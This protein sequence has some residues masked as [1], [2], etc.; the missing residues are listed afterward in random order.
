MRDVNAVGAPAGGPAP[1]PGV[2]ECL[3]FAGE[4]YLNLGRRFGGFLL[5]ALPWVILD[6]LAQLLPPV[7]AK[8]GVLLV[9]TFAGGSAVAVGTHR[10]LLLGETAIQAMQLRL[11][12]LQFFLLSAFAFAIALLV[13]V[14]VM[15]F[16]AA[17]TTQDEAFL[18]PLGAI[19]E[20]LIFL[21]LVSIRLLAFPA[22]AVGERGMRFWR[23]FASPGIPARA[24]WA[25]LA[26]T[27]LAGFP[28]LAVDFALQVA[29]PDMALV[30]A[31][32]YPLLVLAMAA[33]VAGYSSALY[34]R[35]G[36]DAA[37]RAARP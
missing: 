26:G 18:V 19:L 37:V 21:A 7:P 29:A 36:R 12:V 24:Q 4:S 10:I 28:V 6:V 16:I 31:F 13:L 23:A 27:L 33:L 20:S 1:W 35:M 5:L 14:A 25:T 9:I 34:R 15:P 17:L 8:T 22:L 2:R 11:A 30:L 32:L 3:G